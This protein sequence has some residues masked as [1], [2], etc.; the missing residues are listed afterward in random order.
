MPASHLAAP[1][2]ITLAAV[3]QHLQVLEAS[4]LIRTEKQ[5]RVR[6][7]RLEPEGLSVVEQWIRD[8]RALWEKRFDALGELLA[9]EDGESTRAGS[10][11]RRR[12]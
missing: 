4:G 1:L 11:A 7:C 10:P 3:V 2:A 5:G 8:R 9:E 12:P 6:T